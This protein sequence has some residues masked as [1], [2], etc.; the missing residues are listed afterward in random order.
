MLVLEDSDEDRLYLGKGLP[1]DW[2]RSGKE[3]RIDQAPTGW[4]RVNFSLLTNREAK[5][6]VAK[7]EYARPGEPKQLLTH[8]LM[9]ITT[10]QR[11]A[12][13]TLIYISWA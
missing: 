6:V 4:G 12:G 10:F 3:I 2:V 5:R 7:V 1:R 13:H 11:P 8:S 9:T